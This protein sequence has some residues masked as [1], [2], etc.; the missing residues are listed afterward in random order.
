MDSH[1]ISELRSKLSPERLACV[2]AATK[3]LLAAVPYEIEETDRK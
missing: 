2:N 3:E 1:K